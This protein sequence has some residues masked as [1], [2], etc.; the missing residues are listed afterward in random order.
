MTET[1]KGKP[2]QLDVEFDLSILMSRYG[3]TREEM[4]EFFE[5]NAPLMEIRAIEAAHKVIECE[6]G[7]WL[8]GE[9]RK[10]PG[11]RSLPPQGRNDDR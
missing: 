10:E 3:L 8:H 6:I 2:G 7:P 5:A 9:R 1:E 11:G 4:T